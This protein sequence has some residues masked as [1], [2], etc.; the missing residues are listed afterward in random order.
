MAQASYK[1]LGLLLISISCGACLAVELQAQEFDD[2]GKLDP[3]VDLSQW[4]REQQPEIF[5][6]DALPPLSRRP[7]GLAGLTISE[8]IVAGMAVGVESKI[9]LLRGIDNFT[10][11][12]R[13]EAKL[14]DGIISKIS[15]E[16]V[17]FIQERLDP[18]GNKETTE[19]VKRL[20]TE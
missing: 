10:Y 8:V 19:I 9:V 16:E 3:F 17:V 2:A 13:E 18:R 12:A 15:Q 6:Q 4:L 14:F 7:P 20:F 11:I 5:V 1:I